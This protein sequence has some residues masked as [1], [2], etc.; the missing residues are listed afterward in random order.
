MVQAYDKVEFGYPL[1]IDVEL[2]SSKE[3]VVAWW[4]SS[5]PP[6]G[7]ILA[8]GPEVNTIVCHLQEED[9]MLSEEATGWIGYL[10]RQGVKRVADVYRSSGKYHQ[11]N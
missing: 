6:K 3:V 1:L 7:H 5:T 10:L 11:Y 4:G 2:G 9:T 8:K